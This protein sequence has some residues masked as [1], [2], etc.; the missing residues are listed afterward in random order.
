MG[1]KIETMRS[2]MGDE[3][4]EANELWVENEN[5]SAD[6]LS[7]QNEIDFRWIGLGW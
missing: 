3:I 7:V 5:D 1:D 2:V 4:G 6:K